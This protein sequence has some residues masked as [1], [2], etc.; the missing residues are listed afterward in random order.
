M[1]KV[2]LRWQPSP[3]PL[4]AGAWSINVIKSI[5]SKNPWS[6][7]CFDRYKIC[8]NRW[9]ALVKGFKIGLF[10]CC[11]PHY[12]IALSVRRII[13]RGIYGGDL[14]FVMNTD[15]S[16]QYCDTGGWMH[17]MDITDGD[18]NCIGPLPSTPGPHLRYSTITTKTMLLASNTG[19]I[20]L[21]A[22]FMGPTWC[23]SGADKT[24]VGPMLAP[25]TLLSGL[26]F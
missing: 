22:S 4:V 14:R 26:L 18:T 1:C 21:I 24:Q 5:E 23:P 10:V 20:S 7:R 16:C 3:S 6:L 19:M 12:Y 15:L 8:L 25:W 13:R 2:T 11:I 17:V 9:Y